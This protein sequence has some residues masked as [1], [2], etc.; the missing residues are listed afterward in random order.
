MSA[1]LWSATFDVTPELARD[2]ADGVRPLALDGEAFVSCTLCR[3]EYSP[4]VSDSPCARVPVSAQTRA[5]D[6]TPGRN[7]PCWCK[8]GRKYKRCHGRG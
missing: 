6:G 5:A 3:L 4:G 7:D 8:S 1:H 2:A